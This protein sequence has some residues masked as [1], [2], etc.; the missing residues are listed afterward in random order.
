MLPTVNNNNNHNGS[1]SGSSSS[2]SNSSRSNSNYDDKY[3]ESLCQ[4]MHSRFTVIFSV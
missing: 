1:S 4:H 2:S 3:T